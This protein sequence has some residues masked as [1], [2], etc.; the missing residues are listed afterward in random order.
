MNRSDQD[1]RSHHPKETDWYGLF[2]R[3]ARDWLRHND[4]VRDSVKEHLPEL[5]AN[6]DVITRPDDRT[7]QVPVRFLEHYRFRLREPEANRSVGQGKPG[8]VKPGDVLRPAQGPLDARERG[9]GTDIGGVELV[10]ELKVDDI[11]DWLWEEL[12]LPNLEPRPSDALIDEQ[13]VREGW[14]RRGVRSRLDRRRT[15]KEA[16]KRRSVQLDGPDFS[17]EDLRFRQLA[18]RRRPA[19]RAVIF[20]VLDASSSMEEADRKLAKTLFFWVLQG[21]RRQY[22]EI[23]SVFIAHTGMAWE[24]SEAEFFRVTAQGGTQ[25]SSAFRLALDILHQRYS[26]AHYN[27]YLFY[28]SDGDNF[29]EDRE[30]AEAA[31]RRLGSLLNFIGYVEI[32][33]GAGE[34]LDTQMGALVQDLGAGGLPIDSFPLAGYE[35]IWPSIRRFFKQQ[36]GAE[37]A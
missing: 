18:R 19:T 14:D 33:H 6:S 4:K 5:I 25:A 30:P 15:L 27:A 1:R 7:V 29:I 16:I 31:L 37:A 22:H 21:L 11:V 23:S 8:Q 28:A 17:N 2:S 3:G 9:G 36:A 32:S 24:F 20:F 35:D 13:Y 10:L 26:P 12:E 34:A